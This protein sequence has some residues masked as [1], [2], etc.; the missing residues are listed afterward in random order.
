[1]EV[2]LCTSLDLRKVNVRFVVLTNLH[3]FDSFRETMKPNL[4]LFAVQQII[5]AHNAPVTANAFSPDGKSLVT[6]SCGENKLCFW[7]VRS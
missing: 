3:P 4:A 2:S 7:Q 1:M 5:A 6:Y